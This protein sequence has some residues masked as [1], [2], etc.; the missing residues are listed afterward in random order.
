MKKI[1]IAMLLILPLIIVS[2]VLL[3][4]NIISHN[5][6]IAVDN[7]EL[8]YLED[9]LIV[10][11]E[12]E[13]V[14]LVANVYP[15]AA[16]NKEVYWEIE[17]YQ[18]FG[19][20]VESAATITNNG[21][22]SFK[23]YC[24][25]DVVVTTKEG[26]K[27][28]RINII[29]ESGD[30]DKVAINMNSYTLL[31]G[32][33]KEL[34]Y[35]TVPIDGEITKKEFSSDNPDVLEITPNGIL[36]AKK[37]GQANITI[38][39]NDNEE[40]T[41]TKKFIV[42]N[43]FCS[44]GTEFY[45]SNNSVSLESLGIVT[46]VTEI[47][48]GTITNGILTISGDK[49]I[50]GNGEKTVTINKCN[51]NDI[52][53]QNYDILATKNIKLGYNFVTLNGIWKDVLK[54]GQ[55]DIIYKSNDESIASIDSTGKITPKKRGNVTFT[56]TLASNSSFSTEITMDVINPIKYFRLNTSDND[57]KRGILND[58]VI[59][60][61]QIIEGNIVA[62]SVEL[63][64][65]YPE[66]AVWEDFEISL[67]NQEIAKIEGHTIVFNKNIA[68]SDEE[69]V[70]VTAKNSAYRNTEVRVRRTFKVVDGVNCS[71][72]NDMKLACENNQSICLN[73]NITYKNGD[74]A[75][76]N[77]KSL[78]GNGY[79]IDATKMEK[80]KS[81]TAIFTMTG[82]D[83]L[84]SNITIRCDDTSKMNEPNGMSGTP[85][86]IGEKSQAFRSKSRIEYSTFGNSY[87]GLEVH[88]SDIEIKGC[89][90]RNISNFGVRFVS[91]YNEFLD[92]KCDYCNVIMHNNLMSNIVAPAITST[93][94]E[95][96]PNG[97]VIPIQTKVE[98]TG[99]LDVYNWQD[100]TSAK[101]LDRKITGNEAFDAMLGRMLKDA[102]AKE[103]RKDKYSDYTIEED[104]IVYI[105]LGLITAG[106]LFE[107]NSEI[108]IEDE[109][110]K[111]MPLDAIEQVN[112]IMDALHMDRLKPVSLYLYTNE[113]DIKPGDFYNED[114]WLFKKLRGEES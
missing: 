8:N 10:E 103:I 71:S 43:G 15:M 7:V 97:E 86:I 98:I 105:H 55:P 99:F 6:Y 56:L 34:T 35:N 58:C 73:N 29:V 2:T 93:T 94:T 101:M 9:T 85:V 112:G 37:A 64:F 54:S 44:Y 87:W 51:A 66:N 16:R 69:I 60:N 14:Q 57:D 31:T 4:A 107:N 40:I 26:Y 33:N 111:E 36:I 109:R 70:T 23:T 28:D 113:A 80:P 110:F 46:N 63:G 78:Y 11:L 65:N 114:K 53:V 52:M 89:I 104:D 72:F 24:A 3:S 106:G 67:S 30:V 84:V 102:I 21:L 82:S 76:K 91:A 1:I 12:D 92:E 19:E 49:A 48:G 90:F 61:K 83:V 62:N 45:I 27:T 100:L 59:G 77:S 39:L 75:L 22:V 81:E 17:N 95:N 74:T 32:E 42:E 25:F 5:V 47:S 96:M 38:K 79:I 50:L 18:S 20:D 13:N 41:D 68:E 108:I 88:N